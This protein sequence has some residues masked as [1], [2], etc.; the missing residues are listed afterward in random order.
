MSSTRDFYDE[1]A[2]DYHLIFADWQQSVEHQAEVLDRLIRAELGDRPLP[3]LDC[4]C[5]IGTQAI[6]LAARGYHVHGTDLSP[7]AIARAIREA[8]SRSVS[9]SF[10][11]ADVRFLDTQVHGTFDVV[12]SCDNSLPHLL[13]DKDLVA[14]ARSLNAKLVPGGLLVASIRDYDHLLADR[15]RSELPRVFDGPAGRRIVFQIWDWSADGAT[16][17]VH[18]FIVQEAYGR[19]ST[20]HHA[21]AYR[22]LRREELAGFLDRAGFSQVRWR[23]PAETGYYQ[24]IVTAR[25]EQT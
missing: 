20:S 17:V 11:V 12:I 9:A 2:G 14:G 6:G 22:P 15:P 13:T 8:E 24:P 23:M 18:L 1:L 4:T 7:K 21:T 10:S 3:L 25:K 16:Y 5:G 19:W